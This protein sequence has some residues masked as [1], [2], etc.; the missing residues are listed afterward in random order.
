MKL[1]V[2]D[3]LKETNDNFMWFNVIELNDFF[4]P[5]YLYL[6]SFFFFFYGHPWAS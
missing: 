2:F 4:S 1:L 6:S 5:L 3:H